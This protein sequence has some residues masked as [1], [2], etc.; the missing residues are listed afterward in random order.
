MFSFC[1]WR[2]VNDFYFRGKVI[3][4]V[5]WRSLKALFFLNHL[6]G[7]THWCLMN[8]IPFQT[9]KLRSFFFSTLKFVHYEELHCSTEPLAHLGKFR[10]SFKPQCA[11][12]SHQASSLQD[13]ALKF[14]LKFIR[15]WGEKQFSD[16]LCFILH[17]KASP[18]DFSLKMPSQFNYRLYARTF[19]EFMEILEI[20]NIVYA[21]VERRN[22]KIELCIDREGIISSF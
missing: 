6:Q 2:N 12:T 18:F 1:V 10:S 19:S 14:I 20:N 16:Y 17:Y 4:K 7:Q 8:Y 22:E 3:W 5:C 13:F 9:L 11:Q 15:C 21:D